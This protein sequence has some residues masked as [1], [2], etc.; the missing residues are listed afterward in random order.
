[1]VVGGFAGVMPWGELL[2]DLV[3]LILVAAGIWFIYPPAGLIVGGVGVGGLSLGLRARRGGL[4]D[5]NRT[6]KA[7][8]R[9]S[10]E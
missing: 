2:L 5:R 3:A 1:M 6:Y 10:G 8:E 9:V 7:V 4:P